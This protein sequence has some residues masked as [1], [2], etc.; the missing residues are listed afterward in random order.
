MCRGI[1]TRLKK[2]T[3]HEKKN[4][5][6]VEN[7]GCHSEL[8]NSPPASVSKRKQNACSKQFLLICADGEI[9]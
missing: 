6:W 7:R 4:Q 9:E 8:D 5:N 1:L 2:V 3:D